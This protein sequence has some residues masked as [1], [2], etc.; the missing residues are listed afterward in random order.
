MTRNRIAVNVYDK[1]I[2]QKAITE[3]FEKLRLSPVNDGL[4][5]G[6]WGGSGPVVDAVDP[7]TNEPIAKIRTVQR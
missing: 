6:R 3:I 5:N 4:F 2:N 7:A 1:A